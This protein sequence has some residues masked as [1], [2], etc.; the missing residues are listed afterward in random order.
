MALPSNYW[1]AYNASMTTALC[2]CGCGQP[3][4]IATKN[5]KRAG[6]VK[7]QPKRYAAG[8]HGLRGYKTPWEP[9]DHRYHVDPISGCHLWDRCMRKR[10]GYPCRMTLN[11]QQIAPH[12]YAYERLYGPIPAGLELDHLC[13]NTRCVNPEHLEAVTH[14]ENMRRS[15]HIAPSHCPSGHPWTPENTHTYPSGKRR[16]E[17]CYANDRPKRLARLA[18]WRQRKV[19][20]DR[21]AELM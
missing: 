11:G 9:F 18:T 16:C 20:T 10:D 15:V 17:A 14:A 12:R 6:W 1:V 5:D 4:P 2:A 7:G 21:S 13:R 3:T 19:I 8:G